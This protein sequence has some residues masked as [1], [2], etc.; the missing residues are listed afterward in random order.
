MPLKITVAT[1]EAGVLEVKANGIPIWRRSDIGMENV[2]KV[3][4]VNKNYQLEMPSA[5]IMIVN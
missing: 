1:S 4:C 3:I 5:S 2:V